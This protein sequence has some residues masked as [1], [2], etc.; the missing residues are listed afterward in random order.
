MARPSASG[1][2][3]TIVA[4]N[5]YFGDNT[6]LGWTSV[7]SQPVNAWTWHIYLN[8]G[9]YQVQ[10]KLRMSDGSIIGG[11]SS[12]AVRI[13][14]KRPVVTPPA[15]DCRTASGLWHPAAV[16]HREYRSEWAQRKADWPV[17]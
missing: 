16:V 12:C 15:N 9:A 7:D 3:A 1:G 6:E 8:P 4:Y 13:D 5:V 2:P 14:V 17:A 11:P 10:F